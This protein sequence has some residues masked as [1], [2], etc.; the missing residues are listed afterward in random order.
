MESSTIEDFWN[1]TRA[2]A[3][4]DQ[5][6]GYLSDGWPLHLSTTRFQGEWRWVE[7][8]VLPLVGEKTACLDV[9]C[10]TGL[11]LSHFARHFRC[12]EGIDL[13]EQM[14]ASAKERFARQGLEHVQVQ[15]G[16][17][18]DLSSDA[19]FDF[20][21]VGGVLMYLND[22]ALPAALTRLRCSLKPGG[23]IVFREGTYRK[24]TY[25][26]D[27]PIPLG[28][29]SPPDAPRP[30]YRAIYRTT[31]ALRSAVDDA[32]FT[33]LRFQA[34]RH[35]K[36]VDMKKAWLRFINRVSRDGLL[37]DERRADAWARRIH[38]VRSIACILPYY[39]CRI[40]QIPAWNMDNHWLVCRRPLQ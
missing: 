2:N 39:T 35:Y 18:E 13:S 29:L 32:G 26:R 21:F 3:R 23:I 9:G 24:S 12:A 19:L 16:K 40:F 11:W 20:I 25:Y 4:A 27:K 7:Q 33:I 14:V 36:I 31:D 8:V 10:G 28:L 1:A 37:R 34:N 5:E 17:I 30:R 38:A 6:S 15:V 22:D